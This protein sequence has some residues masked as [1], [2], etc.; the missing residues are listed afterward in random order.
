MEPVSVRRKC[1]ELTPQEADAMFFP[2]SGGKPSKARA[3]CVDCPFYQGCLE[4]AALN[5]LQGFWA[6]L[7]DSER[8]LWAVHKRML[9]TSINTDDYVPPETKIMPVAVRTDSHTWMDYVE[10][11]DHELDLL[12]LTG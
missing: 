8:R 6:G 7:T 12:A 4:E 3:Y 9:V 5:S 1:A 10:P 2:G 11:S